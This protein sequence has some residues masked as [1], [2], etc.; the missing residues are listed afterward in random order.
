[1][2]L[3]YNLTMEQH[4]E[5]ED[6]K[7]LLGLEDLQVGRR[8]ISES[9]HLDADQ[10]S[11]FAA[12]FD[13]QPFHLDDDL[14]RASLFNGLAAS[15]WHTAA[16]TMRLLVSSSPILGGVIGAGAEISWP[17]PTRP[18]DTLHVETEVIE[19][20]ESRSRPDRGIVTVTSKTINQNREVVQI[21]TSK[22]VVP[23]RRA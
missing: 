10:I 1:M 7:Q 21:L 20:R 13:P 6:E 3:H 12:R 17:I 11:E 16:I 15:G 8:F 4:K 9:Y 14:A 22:L 18:G 2:P 23:K 5:I 19:I